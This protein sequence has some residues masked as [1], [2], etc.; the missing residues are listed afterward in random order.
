MNEIRLTT[1]LYVVRANKKNNWF[2]GFT[3]GANAKNDTFTD[4]SQNDL[5]FAI[6]FKTRNEAQKFLDAYL[7]DKKDLISPSNIKF[8]EVQGVMTIPY[9]VN[10]NIMMYNVC[11]WFSTETY[12]MWR[13]NPAKYKAVSQ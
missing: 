13:R 11:C 7:E 3:H 8:Y 1:P 10:A 2:L 9:E 6:Y 12:C 4:V 5:R